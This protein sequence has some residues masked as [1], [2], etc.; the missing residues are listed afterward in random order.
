MSSDRQAL[1]YTGGSQL[2]GCFF[3]NTFV[4]SG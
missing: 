1:K 2:L 4:F 3:R